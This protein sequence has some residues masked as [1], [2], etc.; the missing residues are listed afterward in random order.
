MIGTDVQNPYRFAFRL[1]FFYLLFER[2]QIDP[3]RTGRDALYLAAK[4]MDRAPHSDICWFGDESDVAGIG[5]HRGDTKA[6]RLLATGVH[7]DVVVLN[8]DAIVGQQ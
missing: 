8:T 2:I 4:N 5:A 3:G 1:E 7:D 6:H